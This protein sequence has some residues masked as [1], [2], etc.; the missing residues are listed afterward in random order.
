MDFVAELSKSGHSRAVF[1][2]G[3]IAVGV[4]SVAYSRKRAA[5]CGTSWWAVTYIIVMFLCQTE[6]NFAPASSTPILILRTG[7]FFKNV[8]RYSRV[9]VGRHSESCTVSP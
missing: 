6:T 4:R 1:G 2:D 8:D 5:P 3:T 9:R 7:R